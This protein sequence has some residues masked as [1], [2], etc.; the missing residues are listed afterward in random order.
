MNLATISKA[1]IEMAALGS[2][3]DIGLVSPEW[4]QCDDS[5]DFDEFGEIDELLAG[6]PDFE[7]TGPFYMDHQVTPLTH[8][9]NG[10]RFAACCIY[11]CR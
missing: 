7:A 2:S 9:H 1:H 10:C 5:F 11:T 8:P 3:C 6:L 4:L